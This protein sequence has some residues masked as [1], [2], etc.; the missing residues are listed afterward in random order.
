MFSISGFSLKF[1]SPVRSN[2]GPIPT[3]S[4]H[5]SRPS[6]DRMKLEIIKR[7]QK[8]DKTKSDVRSAVGALIS[9]LFFFPASS[10]FSLGFVP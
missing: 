4:S 7:M 5:A 1:T 3:A 8:A 9:N 2:S 6:F 10:L